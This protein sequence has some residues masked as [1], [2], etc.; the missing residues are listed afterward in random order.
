MRAQNQTDTV[1]PLSSASDLPFTLQVKAVDTGAMA[2]PTLQGYASAQY[3]GK[4]ILFGGRTNGLHGFEQSGAVNFPVSS[5]NRDVWVI[6]PVTM[7]SWH[8][9]L[10]DASAGLSASAYSALTIPDTESIQKGDRLY[11]VGGCGE[12]PGGGTGTMNTLTAI[13]L[14]GMMSWAMGGTGSAAPFVRQTSDP[15]LTVTGGALLQL[16][17]RMQLVFGQNFNGGYTPGKT[18]AYTQQR[19][20]RS[21]RWGRSA[22]AA[23]L[24]RSRRRGRWS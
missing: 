24:T 6:D 22:S 13:S 10:N 19:V 16:D 4:W 18:G 17:G 15:S 21:R 23:P 2:L 20:S 12:T 3:D 11:V 1:T 8:R 5:Q 14:P 9:S 7:Q